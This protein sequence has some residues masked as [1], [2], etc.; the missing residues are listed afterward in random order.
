MTLLVTFLNCFLEQLIA[1]YFELTIRHLN[2]LQLL[3]WFCAMPKP[4]N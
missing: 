2:G 4:K 1:R 3:L